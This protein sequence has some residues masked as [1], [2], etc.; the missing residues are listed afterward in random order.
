MK[1]LLFNLLILSLVAPVSLISQS[2]SDSK[3]PSPLKENKNIKK[4]LK[5]GLLWK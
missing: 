5:D 3:L 4:S 1:K 2:L